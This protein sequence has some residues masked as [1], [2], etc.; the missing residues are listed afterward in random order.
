M[1][2]LVELI[3]LEVFLLLLRPQER[4]LSLYD[5][6]HLVYEDQGQE[7]GG[8]RNRVLLFKDLVE[9]LDELLG[10]V[11][12]LHHEEG[13]LGLVGIVDDSEEGCLLLSVG[14]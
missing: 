13:P 12:W 9:V 8:R 11:S 4:V 1:M 7:A 14:N 3:H 2:S 6:V 10:E 5:L